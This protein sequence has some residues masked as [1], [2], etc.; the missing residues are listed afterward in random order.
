MKPTGAGHRNPGGV[1]VVSCPKGDSPP[2]AVTLALAILASAWCAID[3]APRGRVEPGH[4]ERHCTDFTVYTTAGSAFFDGREPYAVTNPRGWSYLYPPIFAL[5]VAPLARLDTVTQVVAWFAISV[6]CCF[7]VYAESCRLWR[8]IG[9]RGEGSRG[10]REWVAACAVL[11]ALVPTLECLQRGQVGIAILYALLLG[12]RLTLEG[13]GRLA[14]FLGGGILAW[15][16]A[17]KLIPA[18]PV[19]FLIWQRGALAL[20]TPVRTP[21]DADRAGAVGLGVL[22]GV[23]GFLLLVPAACL[24][25]GANLRHVETWTRKVVTNPDAGDEAKFHIDSTSNQSL[26]NAAHRL[27][28]VFRGPHSAGAG[29]SPWS[30]A[31]NEG[32]ARWVRD[33]VFADLR[34]A[35]ATTRRLVRIT[36]AVMAGLLLALATFPRRDDPAGQ[37]AGFGLA[38][39]GMLLLSP[40]AWSHYYMTLIPGVLAVPLWL[41]LRGHPWGARV[42][43][44]TPAALVLAHYLAKPLF[45]PLGLL[46]LGTS[47]W[48]LAS[49]AALVAGRFEGLTPRASYRPRA[50]AVRQRGERLEISQMPSERIAHQGP[51]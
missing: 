22:T 21:R 15:P 36:Q 23:V 12:L 1:V 47:A 31:R 46:G 42:S 34:K 5:T 11:T 41:D 29:P 27:A 18:L 16:V 45:G 4:V 9:S 43:A 17:V 8:L 24:G 48:F 13:R 32:E 35:D 19:G 2:L 39:V 6:L 30:S 49:S 33:R 44:A 14:W 28:T 10:L 37:V 26:A 40:V 3:V 7:G 51:C 38:C 20:L 25:W 50:V